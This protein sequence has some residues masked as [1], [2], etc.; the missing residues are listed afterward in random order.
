MSRITRA[1]SHSCCGIGR[2]VK[3]FRAVAP[4]AFRKEY[5]ELTIDPLVRSRHLFTPNYVACRFVTSLGCFF[6]QREVQ[7]F[8]RNT[9]SLLILLLHATRLL[10][11]GALALRPC[12]PQHS[13]PM[14]SPSLPT[15]RREGLPQSLWKHQLHTP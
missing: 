13:A 8:T 9:S 12:W 11:R 1:A 6:T 2:T 7:I 4:P 14:A 3:P 10:R 15:Q 5:F